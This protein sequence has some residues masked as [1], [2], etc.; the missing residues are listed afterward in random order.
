MWLDHLGQAAAVILL[1][2]LLVVVA[3]FLAISGGLAF[4]LFWVRGKTDWAFDK[5]NGYVAVGQKYVHRGSDLI[6]RPFIVAGRVGATATGTAEAVRKRVKQ[7]H[8]AQ[9]SSS[10]SGPPPPA[11]PPASVPQ[12]QP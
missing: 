10:P 9:P 2:E 11:P 4:G 7:V 8:A 6:A 3:I 12:S 5:V 1:I